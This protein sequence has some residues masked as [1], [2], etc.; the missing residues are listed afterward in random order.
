MKWRMM[1][2]A[3]AAGMVFV[4]SAFADVI[5]KYGGGSCF[6]VSLPSTEYRYSGVSIDS[7]SMDSAIAQ[8]NSSY[9]WSGVS[10]KK[11]SPGRYD[12]Y[13]NGCLVYSITDTS[14]GNSGG[15]TASDA[16][17]SAA[18]STGGKSAASS[19][20]KSAG[21]PASN[22]GTQ[23]A[24]SSEKSTATTASSAG[25]PASSSSIQAN[26]IVR[27][28]IFSQA[29]PKAQSKKK[30][31]SSAPASAQPASETGDASQ[32]SIQQSIG[33][34]GIL[35]FGAADV[36]FNRWEIGDA[37]GETVGLNPS[38]TWGE[39]MAF[40]LTIPFHVISGD[41][42]T[43]FGV[44]LDGAFTLPFRGA[45][46]NFSAGIHAYGMGF[47][48]GDD[49]ESTCGG[50]PFLS[51]NYQINPKWILSL[52]VL[53]E[54]TKPDGVDLVTEL[55]PGVNLGY[56]ITENI[57]LNGYGIYHKDLDSDAEYDGYT[58]VGGD[59][60]LALGSW[61][62]SGGA[63]TSVGVSDFTSWEVYLGSGWVF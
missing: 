62:L 1:G 31:S 2:A 4:S 53:V 15:T 14:G 30:S 35:T 22:A 33:E 44:G 37:D 24:S 42:D 9:G 63:K 34:T 20:D 21:A 5:I 54:L 13:Y 29:K 6:G 57:A 51:F 32:P 8:I 7:P 61:S 56:N 16:G 60:S 12:Y 46:D 10:M 52:G 23:E 11:T 38:I 26:T 49:T 59:L 39:S 3:A 43:I 17:K 19:N 25:T 40:A 28:N 41:D 27:N 48:G 18:S 45:W 58:D 55:V 47:F 50:G 36:F